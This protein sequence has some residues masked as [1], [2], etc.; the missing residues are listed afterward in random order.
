MICAGGFALLDPLFDEAD[1]VER[2]GAFS[3]GAVSHAG[4]MK[5]RIQ[6]GA[7]R[8]ISAEH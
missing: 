7:G 2:V 3:A 6:F 4:T 1:L 5:R 8:G